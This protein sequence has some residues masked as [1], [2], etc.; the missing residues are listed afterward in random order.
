MLVQA[1]EALDVEGLVT[2]QAERRHAVAGQELQRSTPSPIRFERWMRSYVSAITARTPSSAVPWPPSPAT[3]RCRI[4]CRRARQAAPRPRVVFG[5]VVDRPFGTVEMV[6][7]PAAPA[8]R[9][10]AVAQALVGEGAADQTS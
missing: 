3:N 4:P 9:D 10:Q 6:E 2:G 8:I 5:G 1:G 7:G